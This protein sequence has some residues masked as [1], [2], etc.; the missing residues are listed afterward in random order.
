LIPPFELRWAR[1][2]FWEA[3]RLMRMTLN[4]KPDMVEE[5][6]VP[7]PASPELEKM[8]RSVTMAEPAQASRSTREPGEHA[9][10]WRKSLSR[11][12]GIAGALL[13][14]VGVLAFLARWALYPAVP[15]GPVYWLAAIFLAFAA[16]RTG[17]LA[18]VATFLGPFDSRMVFAIYTGALLLSPFVIADFLRSARQ[19]ARPQ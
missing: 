4:P 12:V 11:I 9:A 17:A 14:V 18:Y 13:I 10:G 19:P 1:A 16:A 8:Y 7:N 2:Y 5:R 15:A 3:V 6:L